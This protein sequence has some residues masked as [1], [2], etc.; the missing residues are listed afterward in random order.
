MAAPHG[1][2]IWS[3]DVMPN[4]AAT[5]TRW[6]T[7][8]GSRAYLP[9]GDRLLKH[10][11]AGTITRLCDC[12][13]N[14]FDIRVP[15]DADVDPFLSPKQNDGA[16]LIIDYRTDERTEPHRTL[17]FI[18][19][20]D[21]RGLL[22]GIEVDYCANAYPVPDGIEPMEPPFQIHGVLTR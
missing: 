5:A 17:S 4:D 20:V 15:S 13:C 14:S 7:F 1:R 2:S 18:V 22:S 16:A 9:L 12:G 21:A 19:F 10:F 3:L 8:L 6:A 11:A